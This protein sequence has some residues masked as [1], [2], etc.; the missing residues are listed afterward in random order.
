MGEEEIE[1]GSFSELNLGIRELFRV[2]VPGAY[3]VV[4]WAWLGSENTRQSLGESHNL[5]S[6]A[7][8]I[9]VG[10][11]AYGL[12]VHERWWPYDLVF[13]KHRKSLNDAVAA[14]VNA[15]NTDNYV[16]EYKYFLETYA[17]QMKD[18]I[19]YFSSFYYMLDEMSLI[20]AVAAVVLICNFFSS[21]NPGWPISTYFVVL[22]FV[23]QIASLYLTVGDGLKGASPT[24][25]TLRWQVY[26]L[27]RGWIAITGIW[28]VWNFVMSIFLH[29]IWP[30]GPFYGVDSRF[31]VLIAAVCIF[32]RLAAKQWKSIIKEQVTLVKE[33][34]DDLRKV[35]GAETG[36]RP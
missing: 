29:H 12:Q 14:T 7:I 32:E 16:S 15:D 28:L 13:D 18:R 30:R 4:L 8:S 1:A 36:A 19:H 10:L 26:A 11:L 27:K 21:L 31:W 6:I 34:R 9:L 23:L 3:A 33:K 24:A 22:A 17:Q 5:A 2:V 35:L 20:S 25:R